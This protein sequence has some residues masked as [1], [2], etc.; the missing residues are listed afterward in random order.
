MLNANEIREDFP[1]FKRLVNGKPLVYFDSTAT[2]QRPNAV[3]EA[4]DD[5]YHNYNAN[6]HRGVYTISDE[7][8][9]AYENARDKVSR[10]INANRRESVVFTRGTTESI[11][12]VASSWGR[13]NLKPGDEILLS[14]MEHHSNLVPW[15]LIAQQTGARLRFIPLTRDGRLDLE[16]LPQLLSAKT[17][18]VSLT[19]VSNV[20]GTINPVAT[21]IKQAHA[22]G[23]IVMIDGA[24]AAP[25]IRID[26][27]AIDCDF[28]AFSGHKMLGPT[29]TGVLYGK[30]HLLESMPPY[31]GGGDMITEVQ[32]ERSTYREPP[33]KFEAGTPNIAGVI[34]LGAAIDYLD[35]LG[36]EAIQAHERAL[37]RFALDALKGF[38]DIDIYGPIP[39]RSGVI[40]FN[41]KGVHPHDVATILDQEGIAIR[42]GH[43]CAQPLMHWLNVPAT[44]RASFYIYN[45]EDDVERLVSALRKVQE[46]FSAASVA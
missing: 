41:M 2:T 42:A 15:Q 19:Y 4:M 33:G 38:N 23:A 31:H 32:L 24:Q 9:Q 3:I 30:L 21:I 28:L 45:T 13:T 11:N 6:V 25:H 26:V 36:M 16:K 8:T 18:I 10:F 46:I 12:L 27:Q 20:L 22:V 5:Y 1:I 43:H 34:G 44:N 17:K 39:E 40:A 35:R 37:V 14:V 29:G 7:A